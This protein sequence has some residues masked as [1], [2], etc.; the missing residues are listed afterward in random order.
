[1]SLHI[2]AAATFCPFIRTKRTTALHLISAGK[3]ARLEEIEAMMERMMGEPL[4]EALP[5]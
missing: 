1:M 2:M 5:R 3:Q 4:E